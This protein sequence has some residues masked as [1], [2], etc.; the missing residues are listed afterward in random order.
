[1]IVRACRKF[2]RSAGRMRRSDDGATTIEFIIW[3]PFFMTLMLS[4]IEAGL[5]AI[6]HTMLESALDVTVRDLR[7]GLLLNPTHD[8]IKDRVCRDTIV[9][10]RCR[11]RMFIEMQ[12]VDTAI[13]DLPTARPRCDN[14]SLPAAVRPVASLTPGQKN[15]LVV[16]RACVKLRPLFFTTA[17]GLSLPRDGAGMYA[18]STSSAFVN[19]PSESRG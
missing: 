5:V 2:L 9:I 13:W 12:T 15:D 14:V 7:L 11:E 16:I 1:M 4:S 17:G 18:L 3:F 8:D 6:Q 19:E 10:P